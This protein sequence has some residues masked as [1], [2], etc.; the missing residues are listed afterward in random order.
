M[1]ILEGKILRIDLSKMKFFFENYKKYRSF[2][3]GRGVNQYILFKELP[4]GISPF[5]PRNII[6]IG[7]GVLDGTSAPTA[8]RMNIDTKNVLTGG[9]GSSNV[10]GNFGPE[11]KLA[12]ISNIIITGR[13]ENLVYI[14][15]DN[16]EIDIRDATHLKKKKISETEMAIKK[17]IGNDFEIMT[18]GPAGEN[19]VRSA[20]VII[21][22][23]RAAARCGIGA[24][25]GSKNLKAIAVRGSG[26]IDIADPKKFEKTVRE[27]NEKLTDTKSFKLLRKYGI[28]FNEAPWIEGPAK[29]YKSSS[30]EWI[31]GPQTPYKNFSGG[32]PTNEEEKR[33][34]REEFFKYRIGRKK[35][36]NACPIECWSVYSWE[37]NGEIITIDQLQYNSVHNFGYKLGMFDPKLIL[38]AHSLLNDLGL[39]EDNVCGSIGWALECYEKGLLTKEDTGGI[40]LKWGDSKTLFELFKMIAYREEFGDLLAEGCKRASEKIGRG[41][42]KCCVHVKG[43]E[44]FETLWLSPA[45]ALGTVVSPRGGTHTRGAIMVEPAKD[46]LSKDQVKELF[47][48]QDIGEVTSYKN[49]EKMV[50]FMEKFESVL[51]CLGMCFFVHGIHR[52]GMLL[53]QDLSNLLSAAIGVDITPDKLLWIGERTT[54]VE[55]SFN[56]LHTNW[57]RKD[58]Y[59]P[60]RFVD[61][62]LN[63]K[64]RIDLN[65]W[66][67]MLDHYYELH[68][69]DKK[70]GWPK[71]KTLENLDLKEVADKLEKYGKLH[72]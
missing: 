56:V 52:R 8:C 16:N 44:L 31:I 65:K 49:K 41:T 38:K 28:Y 68:G 69:W 53:P 36:C 42:K 57:A 39:D 63:R 2:L 54:N 37:E 15:I 10:G 6:A 64:Y 72:R 55:K 58:D 32:I 50:F 17:N 48:I 40:E 22:N 35:C 27:C 26:S 66:N 51:D 43:Q 4:I 29:L 71:R 12:G 14:S 59:P 45:W 3:G 30:G 60:K 18:I 1:K 67:N 19:L 7:A 21:N 46:A 24:V 23:G 13:A 61:V 70:T 33:I 47:G 9:I 34:T 5:D 20:C 11:M 25:M 62:P